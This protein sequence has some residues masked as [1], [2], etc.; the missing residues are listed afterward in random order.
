MTDLRK[1]ARGRPCMV[2]L[3]GICNGNPQTTV[4]AHYRL[5][6]ISG[7]GIK[8]PDLI[9]AWACSACHDECD[10]RTQ[11]K[12]REYVLLAHAEGVFRTIYELIK[13]G[14]KVE[15]K[16]RTRSD[17]QNRYLWGVCYPTILQ[18]GGETLSGWDAE[19]LHEYFLGEHFGWETLDGF[20]RKRLRPLRRSSKLTRIEFADYVGFIQRKAAELGIFIPDPDTSP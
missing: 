9:G 14:L 1:A 17:P 13:G 15:T 18:A 20:G 5:A 12:E 19:D 16:Q 11:K 7:M 2:R 10:R 8:A 4:L 3:P 6:G